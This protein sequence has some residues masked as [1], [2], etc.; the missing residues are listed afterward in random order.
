MA[1][2]AFNDGLTGLSNRVHFQK[3]LGDCVARL[4]RYGSAFTLLYLDLDKFKAVND[5]L[6]HQAGDQLLIEVGKRLAAAV[7][8]ADVV[9]RLGGDEF[10]LLLTDESDPGSVG[11]LAS[12][13]IEQICMPYAIDGHE[14][15]VGVS[16]GIAIAPVD[17]N[18]AD[19][20]V[21]N[22]DLALYRAKAEGGDC[23]CFFETG[24]D[25]EAHKRRELEAELNEA[26]QRNEFVLHY[27]P[28]V[29]AADSVL[30]GMEALIR[31]NHPTLGLVPAHE[32]MPLAERTGLIARI[33]EWTIAEA[34][35]ALTQLPEHLTVAI[36]LS[37]KHF[38]NTDVFAVIEQALRATGV[39]PHRLELEITESL[40]IDDSGDATGRLSELKKLG[41]KITMDHFGTGYSSLTGLLKFPFDKIKIDSS[42]VSDASEKAVSRETVRAIMAL[43]R[44]LK[45]A[46][47]SKGVETIEQ[48]EFLKEAGS[49]QLQGQLF[50]RPMRLADILAVTGAARQVAAPAQ[51]NARAAAVA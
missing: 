19:Q 23:Y 22:A 48:A 36:N 13:L 30:A 17:G 29:T 25:A 46:V 7:R 11:N 45:I 37:T 50:A 34:C 35:R 5:T 4:D 8:K 6:G 3:R 24:L 20:L 27:Q 14:L 21:R 10:A 18:L 26:L 33:G 47:A 12:R 43:A 44:A 9:A 51:D 49:D 38:R 15:T 31:W 39:A 32:F 1:Y 2:L 28:M 42:L 41:T 16:I 40:L